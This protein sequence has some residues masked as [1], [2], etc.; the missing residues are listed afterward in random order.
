MYARA[1]RFTDVTPERIAEIKARVEENDGPPEGVPAKGMKLLFDES[2]G[3]AIFVAFFETDADM[4][5]ADEVLRDMDA[6]DVPGT[7][8]SIDQAEVVIERDS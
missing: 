5:Q 3:T 2:Q 6:A 8:A 4:R 7:R 1:V